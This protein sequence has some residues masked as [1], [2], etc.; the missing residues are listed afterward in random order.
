MS[1]P[2]SSLTRSNVITFDAER[3]DKLRKQVMS[4]VT[5]DYLEDQNQKYSQ[6]N[7]K[8]MLRE[9]LERC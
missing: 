9:D 6:R 4:C 7:T 1:G 3:R 8:E 2:D 5:N